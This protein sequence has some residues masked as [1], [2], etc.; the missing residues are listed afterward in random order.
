MAI[1][2]DPDSRSY[3]DSDSKALQR[4]KPRANGRECV[5]TYRGGPTRRNL[6]VLFVSTVAS[7]SRPREE[8]EGCTERERKTEECYERAGT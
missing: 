7:E 6:H 3:R 8:S 5:E 4:A 2:D 1:D